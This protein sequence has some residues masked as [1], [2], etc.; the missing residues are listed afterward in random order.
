MTPQPEHPLSTK[1]DTFDQIENLDALLNES[2]ASS[3]TPAEP[4][5]RREPA[6]DEATQPVLPK[7]VL[8]HEPTLS[9]SRMAALLV[10]AVLLMFVAFGLTIYRVSQPDWHWGPVSQRPQEAVA[11]ETKLSEHSIADQT[12][13]AV[14]PGLGLDLAQDPLEHKN[15]GDE[16]PRAATAEVNLSQPEPTEPPAPALASAVE[17]PA[18]GP[19]ELAQVAKPDEKPLELNDIEREAERLRAERKELEDHKREEGEKMA[20]EARRRPPAFP[21]FRGIDPRMLARNQAAMEQFMREQMAAHQKQ[22]DAM[23]RAQ[24]GRIRGRQGFPGGLGAGNADADR[25]FELMRREMEAFEAEALRLMKPQERAAVDPP[26]PGDAP[27]A[28]DQQEPNADW[29]PKNR[30][31]IRKFN[32]VDP[33]TGAKVQ[34]FQMQFGSDGR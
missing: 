12:Q 31:Q 20:E 34:G 21:G 26:A 32:Y 4:D 9:G 18:Q 5:Q 13:D 7:G 8:V 22:V 23:L 2:R 28:E 1:N 25:A 10:P 17:V 6:A 33:R 3:S 19:T 11:S 27:G 24:Q 30:P 29:P 16:M 14:A 15:S